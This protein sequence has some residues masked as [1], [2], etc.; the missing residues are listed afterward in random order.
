[1]I[2]NITYYENN[3]KLFIKGSKKQSKSL[4]IDLSYYI[5][6]NNYI[7]GLNVRKLLYTYPEL[8]I[9]VTT[10]KGVDKTNLV[11]LS[12]IDNNEVNTNDLRRLIKVQVP[13][14]LVYRTDSKNQLYIQVRLELVLLS[15]CEDHWC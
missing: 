1:M 11:L 3:R 7:N 6:K 10:L 15:T 2:L 13:D 8:S 5:D 4:G 9:R 14:G 12:A